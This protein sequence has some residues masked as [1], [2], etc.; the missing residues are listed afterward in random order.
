MLLGGLA[1]ALVLVL[2]HELTALAGLLFLIALSSSLTLVL[3]RSVLLPLAITLP[4]GL[5]AFLAVRTAGHIL[6]AALT[7]LVAL[8]LG[9][10]RAAL[11]LDL[12]LLSALLILLGGLLSLLFIVLL[13]VRLFISL[14]L[15][16]VV[17]FHA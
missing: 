10:L 11:A 7:V 5:R 3:G 15:V 6:L 9:V 2:I 13:N 16:H 8:A 4:R 12:V 14:L 1:I 17:I